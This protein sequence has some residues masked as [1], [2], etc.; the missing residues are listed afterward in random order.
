[1]CTTSYISRLAT[2]ILLPALFLAFANLALAQLD[3]DEMDR[4]QYEL[5]EMTE[6]QALTDSTNPENELVEEKDL[7]EPETAQDR[8]KVL[9]DLYSRLAKA[10]SADAAMVFQTAIERVWLHSGSDT[11]DVLMTRAQKQIDD[12]KHDVALELLG[13]VVKLAPDFAEGWNRRAYVHFSNGNYNRALGDLRKVLALDQQHFQ[14]ISGLASILREFGDD[15]SA[16]K[17]YRK[18]LQIHPFW[19]SA[20]QAVNELAREVE[21]Q[22]I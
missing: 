15:T 3:A 22:G 19:E 2:G 10:K 6:P 20:T 12:K 4:S 13:A 16:L 11:I 7:P 9:A 5:P 18:A 17:A 14:A 21:G 1:M 8:A